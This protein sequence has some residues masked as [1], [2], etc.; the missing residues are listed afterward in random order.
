MWANRRV[1]R[2][3]VKLGLSIGAMGLLLLEHR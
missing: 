1:E 3:R 2:M